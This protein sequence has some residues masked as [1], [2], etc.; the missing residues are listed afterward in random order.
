M[1][2]YEYSIWVAIYILVHFGTCK[3][4]AFRVPPV[5]EARNVFKQW[6]VAFHGTGPQNV[7]K[8]LD[9]GGL[10]MPG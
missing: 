5:A 6:H 8:I 10:V 1:Y 2:I 4:F 9:T 7:R 3:H